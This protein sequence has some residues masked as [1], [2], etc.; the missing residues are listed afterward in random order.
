M[1]RL[2]SILANTVFGLIVLVIA[3]AVGLGVQISVATL[4]ICAIFGI[5]GA[6]VVIILA[7][8]GVAFAAF[9]VPPPL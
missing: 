4:L 3:N 1:V 5:F 9:L 7:A 6:I 2:R 8:Y